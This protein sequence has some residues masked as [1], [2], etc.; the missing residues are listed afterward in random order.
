MET[1]ETL[2]PRSRWD[3][4]FNP[5][6]QMRYRDILFEANVTEA[7]TEKVLSEQGK[8][9][10]KAQK[11]MLKFLDISP[12]SYKPGLNFTSYVGLLFPSFI[13]G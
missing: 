9:P 13:V 7:L 5:R 8:V 10:V 3:R 4:N 1:L 11:F 6:R 2:V 12:R